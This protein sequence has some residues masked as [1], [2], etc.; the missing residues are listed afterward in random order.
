M[1][2]LILLLLCISTIGYAQTLPFDFE[3][4]ITTSDFIDFDGGTATVIANPQANGIN[5]SATVAQIIRDGGQIWAGSKIVLASNLDF[6]TLNSLSMKVFTTAPVGTTVKFKLEGDGQTERDV[7]TSVTNEWE[8]LTWDF[9]AEPANFNTVVFM[10]DFGNVGDGSENST[11]L[12]DD[13][14]QL[15]GGNTGT[16]IDLPVDFESV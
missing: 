6:S 4:T 2:K 1:K 11:F 12:F 8:T 10:F 16:Q 14:E 3:T 13:V 7:Q 15:I 9:T 5:T